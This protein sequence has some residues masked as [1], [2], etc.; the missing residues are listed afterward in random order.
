M[1]SKL[2]D[3]MLAVMSERYFRAQ[4]ARGGRG[5]SPARGAAAGEHSDGP[6]NAIVGSSPA[7]RRLRE[8]I[9][10]AAQVRGTVLLVGESGTGKEL[11]ASAIHQTSASP[12]TPF[13]AVNCAAIPRDL[14]ESELFGYQRGA[15]SGANSH[16]LGLFR[17][18]EKGT[19]FLDE[20]TEMSPET[21]SKILRAIQERTVRPL[22]S[23]REIAVDVRLIASTNRNP[24][25]AM[26]SG[27]LREDLYYRL[28]A[29]VLRL[30]PLR[31][32]I[33]DIPALVDHFIRLLNSRM[34]RP[35]PV[36]GIAHE[37]LKA[38][39]E[40]PWPGNV[41]ELSNSIEMAMTFG[42][43][44]L[45]GVEDLPPAVVRRNEPALE[46][47]LPQLSEPG[48]QPLAPSQLT[49]LEASERELVTR[50]LAITA[51]NKTRAAK[52]LQI[53]RK[54]LYS[55]TNKYMLPAHPEGKL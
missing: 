27:R 4:S 50:A 45:I 34:G 36:E 6:I 37:A 10:A 53:S 30:P 2:G 17:S 9:G 46:A 13:I 1:F 33:E 18:A 7:M 29:S 42:R 3:A 41:R 49:T 52:L 31:E 35:F 14:I 28:Q 40:Y 26:R 22:G 47:E 32:R 15:F 55:L 16:F 51:G 5:V 24:E 25:E 54:K 8:H 39:L 19:L 20:V 23:T 38:M 44:P 48:S 21:Q 11:V 43:R 12:D